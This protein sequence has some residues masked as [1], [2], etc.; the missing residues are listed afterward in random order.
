MSEFASEFLTQVLAGIALL[1]L[2]WVAVWI[3]RRIDEK[4]SQVAFQKK[5]ETS[6]TYDYVSSWM[7]PKA[8]A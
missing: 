8:V 6:H 5:K 4:K 7:S 1:A 2:E 3:R